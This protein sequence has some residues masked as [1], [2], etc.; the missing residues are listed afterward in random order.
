[1]IPILTFS[2]KTNILAQLWADQR[3]DPEGLKKVWADYREDPEKYLEFFQYNDIGLPI[4]L[5]TSRGLI[6]ELTPQGV[7]IIDETFADFLDLVGMQESDF[8]VLPDRNIGAVI[9]F[10]EMRKRISKRAD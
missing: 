4:S 5:W 2:D 1:M 6:K 10:S 8:E 3:K 7:Q 9:V